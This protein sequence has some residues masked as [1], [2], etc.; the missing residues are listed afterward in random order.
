MDK[1]MRDLVNRFMNDPSRHLP[2]GQVILSIL[3]HDD[4][5]KR[6]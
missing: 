4:I 6:F 2:N 5:Q 3:N 1:E